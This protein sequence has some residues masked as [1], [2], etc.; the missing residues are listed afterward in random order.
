LPVPPKLAHRL[1]LDR[2]PAWIYLD[3]INV[4]VWPGPDLRPGSHISGHPAAGETCVIGPLPDDWFA[5]V[6]RQV[7]EGYRNRRVKLIKRS[8]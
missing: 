8:E 1:G 3:Q 4:F 7:L 2:E 6:Q 5:M